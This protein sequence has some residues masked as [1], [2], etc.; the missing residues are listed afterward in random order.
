MAIEKPKS[1]R[2]AEY[3]TSGGIAYLTYCYRDRGMTD[4]QVSSEIG[5][6]RKTLYNWRKKSKKI[7]GAISLGKDTID[8]RVENAL[9]QSALNGNTM[10]QMYWLNNRKPDQWRRKT[11]NEK[12]KD[13]FENKKLQIELE[14]MKKELEDIKSSDTTEIIVVDKWTG[15][16]EEGN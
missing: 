2:M 8:Q 9:L 5:I 10:A 15:D 6:T 3:E 12:A 4:E 13:E 7:E 14:L 11:D 1:K 16:D